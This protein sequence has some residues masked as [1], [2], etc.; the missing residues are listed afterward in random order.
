[1][2]HHVE[3]S[4]YNH[5]DK[6]NELIDPSRVTPTGNAEPTSRLLDG[7]EDHRYAEEWAEPATLPSGE[8]CYRMYLFRADEITSDDGEPMDPEDYPWDDDHV[9]RIKLLD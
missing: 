1:M 8:K 3:I 9:M 4:A 6:A 5:S 2:A 7:S